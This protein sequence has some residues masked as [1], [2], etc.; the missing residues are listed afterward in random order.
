VQNEKNLREKLEA[1]REV[2]RAG[3]GAGEEEF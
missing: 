3:R 2:L 1:I